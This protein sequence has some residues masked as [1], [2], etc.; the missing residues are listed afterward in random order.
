MPQAPYK[1]CAK[2][3]CPNLV[4]QVRYCDTCKPKMSR[5][6]RVD[7]KVRKRFYNSK[8]WKYTRIEQLS[9]EPLC[10]SCRRLANEVDHIVPIS[11]GGQEIDPNNLQSLCKRCHSKKTLE[12]NSLNAR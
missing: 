3:G 2:A 10:R 4:R 9:L 8:T 11:L 12:E 7:Q 5:A 1:P 6:S